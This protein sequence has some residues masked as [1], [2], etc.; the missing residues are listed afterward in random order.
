MATCNCCGAE[1]TPKD[2]F[3]WQCGA[4]VEQKL[5]CTN[6]GAELTPKDKFCWQCGTPAPA[7]A[8]PARVRPAS[9]QPAPAAQTVGNLEDTYPNVKGFYETADAKDAVS[10]S[11]RAIVWADTYG[12]IHRLGKDEDYLLKRTCYAWVVS[13]VQT[14]NGILA[15]EKDQYAH[16][17]ACT[18]SV[19]EYDDDLHLLSTREWKVPQRFSSPD[20]YVA[21]AALSEHYLF[22]VYKPSEN[23]KYVFMRIC[24]DN[25][26]VVKVSRSAAN[27]NGASIT[28]V[29]R[30]LADSGIL[31]ITG[32]TEGTDEYG[33]EITCEFFAT[34]NFDTD[35]IDLIW[36]GEKNISLNGRPHFFDFAKK[37]MWTELTE[38]EAGIYKPEYLRKYLLAPRRIGPNTCILPGEQLLISQEGGY[39]SY[40]DGKNYL[41]ASHYANFFAHPNWGS[42][43]IKW[44]SGGHG[45]SERTVVWPEQGIAIG[46]LRADDQF[47]V[48]PL[49]YDPDNGIGD[50]G[51]LREVEV[52]DS[53]DK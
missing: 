52:T 41:T 48:Y 50:H 31:Y 43:T 28:V 44:Y 30:L 16:S 40:F 20:D 6:C 32:E 25:G 13:V 10:V 53:E 4:K 2:K 33:D 34:V 12:V 7:P 49:N 1:L 19:K 17:N 26:S 47:T 38:D 24:L 23:G 5:Y 45:R 14:P 8:A 42:D 22:I 21:E 11:D 9:F 15:V 37:I 35:A 18:F 27:V 46:D 29:N 39:F 3:C 51:K 36:K